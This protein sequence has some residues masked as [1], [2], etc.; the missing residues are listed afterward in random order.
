MNVHRPPILPSP[1]YLPRIIDG[2]AHRGLPQ[3]WIKFLSQ[4]Y[5]TRW[6][7]PAILP[8]KFGSHLLSSLLSDP[9]VVEVSELCSRSDLLAIHSG[10]LRQTIDV[11]AERYSAATDGLSWNTATLA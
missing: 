7:Y 10:G 3:C 9:K 4:E 11:I 8:S 1:D 2:T 6:L 5:P